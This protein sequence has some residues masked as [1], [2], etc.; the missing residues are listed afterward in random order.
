MSYGTKHTFKLVQDQSKG[1]KADGIVQPFNA[2]SRSTLRLGAGVQGRLPF[3]TEPRSLRWHT[4]SA[5]VRVPAPRLLCC[6]RDGAPDGAGVRGPVRMAAV[7]PA[8]FT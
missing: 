3:R 1:R 6:D 4:P 8:S 7:L 5:A 2:E